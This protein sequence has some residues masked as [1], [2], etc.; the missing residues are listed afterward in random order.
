MLYRE[1]DCANMGR[2]K[3]VDETVTLIEQRDYDPNGI[4]TNLKNYFSQKGI[5]NEIKDKTIML[6]VS[7]VF[8]VGNYERTIMINTNYNL[9]AATCKALEELGAKK[10][11][12]ADGETVGA[13]SYAFAVTKLKRYL[14][15]MNLQRTEYLYLDE[16][17]KAKIKFLNST[18]DNYIGKTP[19]P[20]E[21]L[22]LSYPICLI[23]NGSL[24]DEKGSI[25]DSETLKTKYGYIDYFI[26]MPKLKANIFAN[27]TL[28]VK[29]NMGIIYRS[30]RLRYHSHIL[31]DMIAYLYTIRTPDL[32]ITDAVISGMG[33]GPM[34]ADPCK[35]DLLICG[36]VGTAVDTVC[37]YLM[38]VDPLKIRHL[39]LLKEWG[40]GSLDINQI[41]IE[42][43]YIIE[44]RRKL[45]LP[46][47]M[48]D[49]HIEKISGLKVY[50]GEN[51]CD[52]GCR[53]MMKAILDAYLKNGKSED[54]KGHTFILGNVD[55]P[56]EELKTINKKT[57]VVYGNC[58]KKYKKY[59]AFYSGCPPDYLIA[60]ALMELQ[61]HMGINPWIMYVKP[62]DFIWSY[63]RHSFALLKGARRN[64]TI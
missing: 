5:D 40:Y 43:R 7:L 31:H 28:S 41:N 46:F 8:A 19:Y 20:F 30:E 64:R 60:M 6:K 39:K 13:A 29:N 63:I 24:S 21:D 12:I 38:D 10:V 45:I 52:S 25:I 35:T 15:K 11:Y 51:A 36:K 26:S 58:A 2:P 57:C 22:T 55:I 32:V 48:P 49:R 50:M 53:G 18:L 56:E 61:A 14:R 62:L 37:S 27:I 42:K 3:I 47:A 44:S 33:Q 1:I 9:I 23:S 17:P 4:L 59:G 54:L 34:E 16:V